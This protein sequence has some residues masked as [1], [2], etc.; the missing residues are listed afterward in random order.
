MKKLLSLFTGFLLL[1]AWTT[2]YAQTVELHSYT[3]SARRIPDGD[4]AGL[5]DRRS[6]ASSV[7]ALSRVRVMLCVAGEFNGD[8]YA[9][10]RQVQAGRTNICVLL[11]RPGR[12]GTNSL[13]YADSGMDVTFDATAVSGDVHLY[14]NLSPPAW[15][16]PLTGT[17]QPDGRRSDPATVVNES[18][19]MTS[20][21]AFN[22]GGGSGTWTLYVADVDAGGTNTLVSWA[23]ELTGA[24][25]APLTWASPAALVYGTP[26]SSTQ[27]NATSSVP[28]TYTYEPPVGTVLKAGS[29]QALAVTFTP[30]D[31]TNYVPVTN[32][33]AISVTPAP[34]TIT[35][36]STNK[37]YGAAR[38]TLRASYSGFVNGDTTNN[39]TA[40]A[41]LST[42]ATA[43]SPVGSY[44]ITASGAAGTNYT[45][46]YVAGTLTIEKAST[47]GSLVSSKNPA[48]PGEQVT[49]TFTAQTVAP[50]AGLPDGTVTFEA[51]G[52]VIGTATLAGG[53]AGFAA[54]SLALGSHALVAIYAGSSNFHPTSVALAPD[55]LINTPP[56]AGADTI[57]R[58]SANGATVLISKLLANDRDADGD[59][60]TLLSFST[61]TT[62][63][64]TL[65]QSNGWLHYLPPPGFTNH[66]RF[67]YVIS[68]GRGASATGM[69]AVVVMPNSAA[70]N[71]TILDQGNGSYRIRFDGI[72]RA[73]YRIQYSD[74]AANPTWHDLGIRTA[75][76]AGV[77]EYLDTPPGGTPH[78][79][80]HSLY[81]ASP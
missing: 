81:P 62:T 72:P 19:R 11:N 31:T 46:G 2:S 70:P 79:F 40:Q 69:V 15:G 4:W 55:Q 75:D 14:R 41:V 37:I 35:A 16:T 64:A 32:Y 17:W 74:D 1:P 38:P 30:A 66:D 71:L 43:A 9:Y 42:P 28:G 20:L 5:S 67:S 68:D 36:N 39:L 49:F 50:G 57:E 78:R 73:S 13:G 33:V 12:S 21:S 45:I 58:L 44:A 80:Y 23:L 34:L 22:G 29:G 51:D 25:P 63:G 65:V 18:A 77:F 53:T 52:S 48:L 8:L 3:N 60:I 27:L 10:L 24:V 6:V 47:T 59:T 26:L 7:A 76:E 54:T 61:N 56:V